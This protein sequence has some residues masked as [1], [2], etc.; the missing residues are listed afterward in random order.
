MD[1][2]LRARATFANFGGRE[3]YRR[4]LIRGRR[5]PPILRSSRG[6]S[7]VTR[8]R[9]RRM[10]ERSA[11][12]STLACERGDVLALITDGL[13]EVLFAGR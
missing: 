12:S 3:G 10:F 7:R 2:C 11:H 6:S 1:R 13:D 4:A 8:R 5:P 9:F